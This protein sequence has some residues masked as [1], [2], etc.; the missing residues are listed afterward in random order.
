[1]LAVVELY[2]QGLSPDEIVAQLPS[3]MPEGVFAALAYAHANADEIA[4]YFE[5]D[6]AAHGSW[7]ADRS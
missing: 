4:G 6:A 5:E 2:E 1:V 3:L 7:L